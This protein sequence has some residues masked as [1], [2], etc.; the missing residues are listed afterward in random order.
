MT[1][2]SMLY[3]KFLLSLCIE[4]YIRFPTNYNRRKLNN[5]GTYLIVFFE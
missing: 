3:D 5:Q 4:A 2:E 1:T